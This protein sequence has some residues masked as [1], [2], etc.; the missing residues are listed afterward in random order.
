M[1]LVGEEI[2]REQIENCV[3]K[4]SHGLLGVTK[5]TTD[6]YYCSNALLVACITHSH[7]N[8]CQ[9]N[10]TRWGKSREV[11]FVTPS[12]ENTGRQFE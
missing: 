4:L 11:L 3:H 10:H 5:V 12:V 6:M 8:G 1:A 9:T 2:V 7:K